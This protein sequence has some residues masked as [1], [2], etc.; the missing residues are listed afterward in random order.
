VHDETGE[1]CATGYEMT[2][3]AN[4]E[5]EEFVFGAFKSPQL[6]KTV[7]VPIVAI[8]AR[9]GLSFG[10]LASVDPLGS[11]EAAFDDAGFEVMTFEQIRFL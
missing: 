11:E 3:K 10:R 7:Q 2:Q 9:S 8:E 1:L 4:L 6:G 5:E